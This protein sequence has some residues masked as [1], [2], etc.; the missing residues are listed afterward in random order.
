[1]ANRVPR[2][3]VLVAVGL[4]LLLAGCSARSDVTLAPVSGRITLDGKPLSRAQIV[5]APLGTRGGPAFAVSDRLGNYELQ[6]THEKK[7][8]VVGKCQ[9]R[10]KTALRLP[11][12]E[13]EEFPTEP[14][15][16]PAMY[17][18][19]SKLE[20]EV[21]PDGGPYDFALRSE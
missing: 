14:E 21:V 9:V 4:S 11:D 7:G 17:N 20:V 2:R 6:Y 15:V 10:I 1:M 5:F 8:A 16:V 18:S 13:G 12:D 19:E 3:A